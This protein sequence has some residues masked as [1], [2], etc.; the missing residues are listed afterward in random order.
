MALCVVNMMLKCCWQRKNY[1]SFFFFFFFST[2]EQ[3]SAPHIAVSDLKRQERFLPGM[4]AVHDGAL[5]CVVF[6]PGKEHRD[7]PLCVLCIACG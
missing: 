5:V 2:V 1:V 4:P 3:L 6:A 7:S